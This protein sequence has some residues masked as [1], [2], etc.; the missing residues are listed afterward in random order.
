MKAPRVHGIVPIDKPSGLTS[1]DVVSRCRRIFGQRQVGHSGT[2]DPM[3][4]GALIVLL[5]E[6]TKLSRFVQGGMKEY[7]TE[8]RLGTQ[9]DSDDADGAVVQRRD[10][11]KLSRALVEKTL[12]Q[13]V[14]SY[15]QVPPRVSAIKVDGKPLYRRFRAGEEVEVLPRRV[16]CA[17][18]E[19]LEAGEDVLRLR[20][21]VGPGFYVRSLGRDL[22]LALGTVGHLG[23]LRRTCNAGFS[24][25]ALTTLQELQRAAR[26]EV[27]VLPM[28]DAWPAERVLQ[29]GA[30]VA[31]DLSHGKRVWIGSLSSGARERVEAVSG[32]PWAA[33]LGQ[34]RKLI[35]VVEREDSSLR[36]IRGF[37]DF[38]ML[39]Q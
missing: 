14:G 34:A 33:V 35:A 22:A 1:H 23:T 18:L 4:T 12:G 19:L 8:V 31:R 10:V 27:H 24:V 9:T 20:A 26:P 2:L 25:G 21:V 37:T 29:V 32:E 6:A 16:F 39:P 15:D 28:L 5:G 13:F 38:A 11:P 3:A 17:E 7:L 30:D 36:V